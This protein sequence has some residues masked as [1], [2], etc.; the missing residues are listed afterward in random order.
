MPFNSAGF[1]LF[2]AA[3][4]LTFRRAPRRWRSLSLVVASY[5]FCC[6]W[7]PAHALILLA[8]TAVAYRAGLRAAEGDERRVAVAVLVLLGALAAFKAYNPIAAAL[9]GPG[10]WRLLAPVGIS[11]YT[12]KLVSYVLDVH[13]GL[14]P[15]E[16][17]FAAFAAYAAFF[18][19]IASG[20]IQ[21]AVDFL[22]Q[23]AAGEAGAASA[24]WGVRRIAFGLFQKVVV[25]DRLGAIVDAV[26]RAPASFHPAQVAL[27]LAAFSL[28]LYADFSGLTDIALGVGLLFGIRGPEN[29]AAPFYA[30]NIQEFW[31]RWHISLTSWLTDY[32]FL[33]LRMSF[34]RHGDLGLAAS[35]FLTLL[36]V[37]V[38][39]GARWNYAIFGA[40]HG[41]AMAISA[42][43]LAPRNRFFA[44]HPAW[45]RAR[46][47]AGALVVFSLISLSYAFF[48]AETPVAAWSVLTAL[49]G[50]G[51]WRPGF[52][53]RLTA[54][55]VALLLAALVVME[56]AR[57]MTRREAPPS[58]AASLLGYAAMLFFLLLSGA[59]STPFIYLQF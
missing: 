24:A 39:H 46:A 29:F 19:Q 3:A 57:P 42:L 43:T 23:L 58:R 31:R 38:W 26:H 6:F 45:A 36:A 15:P 25:A 17:D 2:A 41:V 33:P 7:S 5:A 11:Y 34:R 14:L 12:F 32:L 21:R 10:A 4:A 54:S 16:R 9:A 40:I 55:D 1:L 44:R 35:V 28:Q 47:V 18:P 51:A 37:G 49:F 20:P 52:G 56:A 50:S 59:P 53:L 48:R 30:S 27:G 13:W 22:P 8:A